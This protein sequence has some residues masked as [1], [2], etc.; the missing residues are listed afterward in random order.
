MKT[1]HASFPPLPP[2][3]S[4]QNASG[5]LK[6]LKKSAGEVANFDFGGEMWKVINI[7]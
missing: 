4:L 1:L 7:I 5:R 6:V 2:T 3:S